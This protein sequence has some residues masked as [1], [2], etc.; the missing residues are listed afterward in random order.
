MIHP[1]GFQ[2]VCVGGGDREMGEKES[3]RE[4]QSSDVVFVLLPN[5]DKPVSFPL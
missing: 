4:R 3:D 5:A 2:C 1:A